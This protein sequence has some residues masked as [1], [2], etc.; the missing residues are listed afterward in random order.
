MNISYCVHNNDNCLFFNIIYVVF[1]SNMNVL[2]WNSIISINDIGTLIARM[3]HIEFCYLRLIVAYIK[4]LL[5][6][7]NSVLILD[8][9]ARCLLIYCFYE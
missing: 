3:S 9:T 8:T 5:S 4:K 2:L 6:I 7:N 1:E